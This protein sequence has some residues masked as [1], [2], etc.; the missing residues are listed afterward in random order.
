MYQKTKKKLKL[1]TKIMM[2]ENN[3]KDVFTLERNNKVSWS[4]K[5]VNNLLNTTILD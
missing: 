1:T 2:L 5:V 3:K 4:N